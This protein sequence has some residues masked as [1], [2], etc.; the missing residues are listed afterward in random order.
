MIY[1]QILSDIADAL[2][3]G[4]NPQE[5]EIFF[6]YYYWEDVSDSS[7]TQWRM[8]VPLPADL[9]VSLFELNWPLRSTVG[10]P[11][12]IDRDI[13]SAAVGPLPRPIPVR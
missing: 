7:G 3:N 1:P 4:Q 6:E 13:V 2:G 10:R 12:R 11:L 9:C 5:Y 8:L